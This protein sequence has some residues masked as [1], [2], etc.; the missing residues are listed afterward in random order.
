MEEDNY[1]YISLSDSELSM[2]DEG[3][4]TNISTAEIDIDMSPEYSPITE[5]ISFSSSIKNY[6]PSQPSS[7]IQNQIDEAPLTLPIEYLSAAR[8]WLI[9]MVMMSEH[10]SNEANTSSLPI[11]LSTSTVN[12]TLPTNET[13][14]GLQLEDWISQPLYEM[15]LPIVTENPS[16]LS[17][18]SLP[19]VSTNQ[20]LFTTN[21]N[22]NIGY[23]D[24]IIFNDIDQIVN[25]NR[26]WINGH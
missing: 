12:F 8:D 16:L 13:E 7:P 19:I 18:P 21:Q 6:L 25:H 14:S 2:V 3:I 22:T 24:D 9:S 1:K 11:Q 10:S 5:P 20:T 23:H 4:Y 26:C 15:P 17:T